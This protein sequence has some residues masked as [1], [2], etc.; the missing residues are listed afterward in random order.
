MK[1]IL[2]LFLAVFIAAAAIPPAFA[3]YSDI[4]MSAD[5]SQSAQASGFGY[6]QRL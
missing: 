5:Y 2:S 6:Y 1:K 4:D 3:A